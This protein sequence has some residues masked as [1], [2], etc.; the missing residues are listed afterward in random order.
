MHLFYQQH[1]LSPSG[2]LSNVLEIWDVEKHKGQFLT[3]IC[4]LRWGNP[5]KENK[6]SL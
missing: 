5:L 2:V 4:F 3:P 6:Q 1:F